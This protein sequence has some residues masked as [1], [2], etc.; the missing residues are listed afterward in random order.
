V[1]PRKFR[2]GFATFPYGGNGGVSSESPELKHWFTKTRLAIEKDDR[3][4]LSNGVWCLDKADTPITMCRNFAIKAAHQAGVDCLVM[5]DSDMHPDNLLGLDSTAKPFWEVAFN[6]FC[7]WYD[8]GPCV[9]A[10]PYCGPPP[11]PRRGGSE[12]PYIFTWEARSNHPDERWASL[13]MFERSEVAQR[14][15]IEEVAAIG[16][17]LM[18]LDMRLFE[19][20]PPPWFD[21]EWKDPPYNTEKAS[22]E[23]VYFTRNCSM[24]GIPVYVLWDCWAGHVKQYESSKPRVLDPDTVCGPYREAVIRQY[25]KEQQEKGDHKPQPGTKAAGAK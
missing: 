8:R 15:G 24:Q 21:Y 7:R 22:T 13:R 23:D 4:D 10:A 12:C 1:I 19:E 6:F 2:V 17:G 5:Y 20:L 9:L 3:I 18:M 16:T 14:T 25:L 11:H